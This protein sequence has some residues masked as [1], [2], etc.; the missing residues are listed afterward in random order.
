MEIIDVHTHVFP[1]GI[2]G[3]AAE[4]IGGFYHLPMS[5]DGTVRGLLDG[6]SR[7][8]IS[9]AFIHSVAVTPAHV[10]NINRFI[11]GTVA[12]GNG[13]F[14]GYGAIHPDYDDIPAL[15]DKLVL[16]G[17]KGVKIHPDMQKFALDDKKTFSMFEALEGR[18]PILIHT[19]DKRYCFSGPKQMKK[20]LEAFPGLTC[21]CAHLGGWSEWQDAWRFLSGF[22]NAYID[23][24]SSLYALDREEAAGIIRRFAS[25]RV[26]FGTDYPMWDPK[27]E[28][29]RFMRLPLTDDEKERIL[30]ENAL[31]IM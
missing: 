12:A 21:I 15:I 19:G 27:D 22:E 9:H 29:D 14:T 2:A 30:C 5:G 18:I 6:M 20:V 24:S 26:L 31:G 3:R 7:A 8:G 13:C 4:S 25:E 23:T 11:A 16:S 28:L 10:D 17:M 1:D